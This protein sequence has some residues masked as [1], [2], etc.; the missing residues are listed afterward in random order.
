ME[1][2]QLQSN[3]EW[4]F[5]WWLD[6]L[7]K[8]NIIKNY[9]YESNTFTLAT[10]RSYSILRQ[11]KTKT[12]IDQ[13]SLL[14]EHVYTPDFRIEWNEDFNHRVYR[15]IDDDTCTNKPPFFAIKGKQNNKHYTF[16]EVKPVFD[17]NNMTRLFKLSQKWLY[18]KYGLYVELVIVPTLFKKTF[19]P[20]RYMLTDK[21]RQSRKIDFDIKTIEK[22]MTTF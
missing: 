10:A 7:K 4:Y 5:S 1:L 2:D 11:L 8:H 14:Q 12:R 9:V 18:D 20:S 19:V 21:S 6:D 16:F 17:Q 3:E 22:W 13:L 15:L